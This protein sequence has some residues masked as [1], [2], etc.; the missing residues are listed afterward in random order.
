MRS[1]DVLKRS[2]VVVRGS[3]NILY[4]DNNVPIQQGLEVRDDLVVA[5]YQ[6][7]REGEATRVDVSGDN[8]GEFEW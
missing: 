7:S 1:K 4:A 8:R 5:G 3:T 2:K 6:T